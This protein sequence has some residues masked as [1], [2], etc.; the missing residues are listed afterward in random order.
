MLKRERLEKTV[1]G[2]ATDRVPVAIWRPFPGD[3]QRVA[4]LAQSVIDFQHQYDWDFVNIVPASNYAVVDYGVQD[5][6]QGAPDG[7]RVCLRYP[8]K[9]SLDWTELRPLD[10]TRGETGKQLECVRQVTEALSHDADGPPILLTVYSP[11]AQANRLA[12]QQQLLRHFRTGHDRLRTGLNALTETTL[13][14]IEALKSA[15]IS[16]IYYVIEHAD[17]DILSESEY[18]LIALPFDRRIMDALPDNWWLNIVH[19]H[20]AS[21]MFRFASSYRTQGVNWSDQQPDLSML[22]AQ[23]DGAI[24]GGLDIEL[25]LRQGTPATIRDT[26]RTMMQQSGN[27]RLI[28]TG[29]GAALTT[30][31]ASN[32]RAVRDAVEVKRM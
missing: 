13:R 18:D 30:T 15:K 26:A 4:D 27:R 14:L 24:C 23:F 3:D 25:H 10:P 16:G 2:E 22:R 29:N 32:L 20:G 1:A 12:G 31:P 11:L 8:I 6:W 19:L 9:R 17:H 7:Q 5:E 21:P 28:L